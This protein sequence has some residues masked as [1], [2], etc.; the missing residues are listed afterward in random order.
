MVNR[1]HWGICPHCKRQRSKA[2]IANGKCDLD[3]IEAER[4][5]AGE[6]YEARQADDGWTGPQGDAVRFERNQRLDASMWVII[7]GTPLTQE[8][9]D[10]FCQYRE[11][12]HRVTVD[13]SKPG[14]VVWPNQPALIYQ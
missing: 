8:C 6:A 12:L 13:F 14:D 10:E 2:V 7:P 1:P 11:K 5:A 3:R 4:E 9:Q